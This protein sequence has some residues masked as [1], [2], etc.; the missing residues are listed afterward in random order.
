M[1]EVLGTFHGACVVVRAAQSE[2][3][4]VVILRKGM[5][6]RSE[7]FCDERFQ[8]PGKSVFWTLI[9]IPGSLV[10]QGNDRY[11]GKTPHRNFAGREN[12][13]I[14]L[15]NWPFLSPNPI[16]ISEIQFTGFQQQLSVVSH[17]A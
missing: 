3:F 2:Q 15:W 10:D 5:H 16:P 4:S 6:P 7:F 14:S 12:L 13:L 1:P 11:P 9:L 8:Y 17:P